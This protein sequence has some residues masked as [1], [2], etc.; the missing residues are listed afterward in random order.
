MSR[1]VRTI[2]YTAGLL[3]IGFLI[4]YFSNIV[5]YILASLVMTLIG[6]PVYD[7]L[8]KVR[9]RRLYLPGAIRSIITLVI[10]ISF[11]LCFFGLFIPLLVIKIQELSAMDPQKLILVFSVP[12]EKINQFINH[13]VIRPDNSSVEEMIRKAVSRINVGQVADIF[14]SVAGW[15]G[16]LSVAVFSI[17]FIT[18]FFLKDEK[19]F[20]RAI[21][22]LIPEKH[23][24]A[25]D[26]AMMATR[27][28][29]S[30]Y[31]VGMLLEVTAV[32]LLSMVGLLI[33]GFDLKD[34]LL[35][36]FL[37][38][39]FNIIPYLGPAIGTIL[40]LFVGIVSYLGNPGDRNIFVMA[41]LIIV[42]FMLVQFIDNM[43]IQ[44]YIYSS[45][46]HAHPLEIFL[47]F[48]MAGSIGGL[49]GMILA[50]PAYTVIRVFAK[51]FF[52]NFRLVQSLTRHI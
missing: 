45:S 25:V 36:G 46:V 42:V 35:V 40:G 3:V 26:N 52:N 9:Y 10:L 1:T 7:L 12:L 48:L 22:L 24:E 44:P 15:L 5:L 27:K 51:E 43:L 28:L 33:L 47:V 31:F 34:A 21:L 6:R 49:G 11:I 2:L 39:I 23:A 38:G 17:V 37:A 32:V 4:W 16:N 50:V 30:R 20:S 13:Y 8:D 19:M 18:F 41:S 29:L 14:G